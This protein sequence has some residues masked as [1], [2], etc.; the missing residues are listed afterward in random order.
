MAAQVERGEHRRVA[1][2]EWDAATPKERQAMTIDTVWAGMLAAMKR[3][4]EELG[5][6]NIGPWD[7]FDWGMLN[8]KL[9]AL[10]CYGR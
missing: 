9:S 3:T 10:R 1:Q 4:E 6:D 5:P 8:G 2:A 7:D